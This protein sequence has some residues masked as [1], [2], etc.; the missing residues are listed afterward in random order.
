MMSALSSRERFAAAHPKSRELWE[1]S[2]RVSRGIHH[3]ARSCDPFPI[4]TSRCQGSRKWDVDGNEYIDYTMGHGSLL[5]GH[6]HPSLVEAVSAQLVKGTHYGTE[7]EPGVEWAEIITRLIPAAE[8]VEFVMSGTEANILIAQLARAYTGRTKLLKFAEHFFGWSDHLQVGVFPPYDRPIAGHLPPIAD[9]TV[10]GGTVVIPCNDGAALEKAL[11]TREI[12]ALFIEGGGAH[13]GEIG[14]P[15]ELWHAAR[16]LTREHGTL[17]VIDEVI[18]GF[19]W[20]PGGCQAVVGVTPDLS[21]LGKMVSGGLPGA[22]VCGRA[23]I[24]ELLEIKAG[25]PEWNRYRRV[26]HPG[27]WNANPLSAVAGIATLKI[28]ETGEP[29]K[30]A[31][32][33]AGRLVSELNRQI[34]KRGIE[35]CAYHTASA[36]HFYLG[37]CQR[38]D[39]ELCLDATKRMSSD[40][41]AALDRHLLLNGVNMLRG[42][43]GWLSAVHTDR[44]VAQTTEAFGAALDG[45]LGEGMVKSS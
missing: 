17:L 33:M 22:A 44:D 20:S 16:R 34:E 18:T 28:A 1:R 31:A 35:G 39:R 7:S 23:D 36:I 6:A 12:A 37:P 41:I 42:T 43:I 19:R 4:F 10:S 9:D 26:V 30:V 45:L 2:R 38:C 13:C 5:L 24:M 25:D 27:T 21:S 32:A 29:Q 11:A 15:P 8:K 14:M 3:D 40:L